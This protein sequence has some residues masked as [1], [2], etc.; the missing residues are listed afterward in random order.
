MLPIDVWSS[1]VLQFKFVPMSSEANL[2]SR[3]AA[4]DVD[5][6]AH[7]AA[8]PAVK[9]ATVEENALSYTV[10]DVDDSEEGCEEQEALASSIAAA[11]GR[12]A[13]PTHR[14]AL[15]TTLP[16]VAIELLGAAWHD[17]L[18]LFGTLDPNG[19]HLLTHR[20]LSSEIE[21]QM[22]A[23]GPSQ[24]AALRVLRGC[25][26]ELL[27]A[28]ATD[29]AGEGP[30]VPLETAISLSAV[31]RI[32][33]EKKRSALVDEQ[34]L[35]AM[36]GIIRRHA[37]GIAGAPSKELPAEYDEIYAAL[38]PLVEAAT[39]TSQGEMS[40][41]IK[42]R[43]AA[44]W[45]EWVDAS[46]VPAPRTPLEQAL[47]SL[48]TM[49]T[50]PP[51][52]AR[53]G[54][55]SGTATGAAAAAAAGG[56]PAQSAGKGKGKGKGKGGERAAAQHT[57][58]ALDG[59]WV[60]DGSVVGTITAM[61]LTPRSEGGGAAADPQRLEWRR[62]EGGGQWVVLELRG[63]LLRARLKLEKPGIARSRRTLAWND[64][65]VWERVP[66]ESRASAKAKRG[67]GG[68]DAAKGRAKRLFGWAIGAVAAAAILGAVAMVALNGVDDAAQDELDAA[69]APRRRR[70]VDV[71]RP[72]GRGGQQPQMQ[73]GG[74]LFNTP[75][76]DPTIDL[77]RLS[78]SGRR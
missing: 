17:A 9:K 49:V 69:A 32:V 31:E 35:L 51:A 18:R 68:A 22:A 63:E 73:M 62:G 60:Q 66:G 16:S 34:I 46:C 71:S 55:A 67:G 76:N 10:E 59:T 54:A 15:P 41:H 52:A 39:T 77:L 4:K 8:S 13:H 20:A 74:G 75:T 24:D 70:R 42:L 40:K 21:A 37:A 11:R 7:P 2:T 72:A 6:S 65:D 12:A 38:A 25:I 44:Q 47:A 33:E 45:P 26:D 64:G 23:L 30:A 5:S 61:V 36:A 50:Q 48:W 78:G 56:E 58:T 1:I 3:S 53:G 57:P 14:A 43:Y 27:V 29:G 28:G 19:D